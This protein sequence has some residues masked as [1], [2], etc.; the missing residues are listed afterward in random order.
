MTGDP[1]EEVRVGFELLKALELVNHG[2]TILSCPTCGR[3]DIDVQKIASE[4][5]EKTRHIKMPLRVAIMGCEVN[6]PGEAADADVGLAGGHGLGLIFREG[7]VVRKVS[8]GEM[9]EALLD[10]IESM[11]LG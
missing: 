3:C 1:V 9:V 2:I 10:E 11:V 4:V 6:G 7:Q 8:E 5:E